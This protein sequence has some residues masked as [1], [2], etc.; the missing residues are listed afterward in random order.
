M[1]TSD[2]YEV[3]LE[4]RRL[5]RELPQS[6]SSKTWG[7]ALAANSGADALSTGSDAGDVIL[8]YAFSNTGYAFDRN[9]YALLLSNEEAFL[10]YADAWDWSMLH[11]QQQGL[12]PEIM[13]VPAKRR[14]QNIG[15]EGGISSSATLHT[16]I[17]ERINRGESV[18]IIGKGK[19]KVEEVSVHL[20]MRILDGHRIRGKSRTL[21]DPRPA[22]RTDK[23]AAYR[24]Y[25]LISHVLQW[26]SMSLFI[27]SSVCAILAVFNLATS[28]KREE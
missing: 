1:M 4:L 21:Q 9:F 27:A 13:L 12:V 17:V 20:S 6:L 11:L 26:A 5:R 3:A 15:L 18:S 10:T 7:F 19:L 24:A 8:S 23:V 25:F 2:S 16:L 22:Y 14:V 28:N